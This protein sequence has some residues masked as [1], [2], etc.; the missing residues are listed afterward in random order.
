MAAP[1]RPLDPP[2]AALASGPVA[3]LV[4]PPALVRTDGVVAAPFCGAAWGKVQH[5]RVGVGA[6]GGTMWRSLCSPWE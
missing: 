5:A 4:P 3:V 1:A 2:E 6:K